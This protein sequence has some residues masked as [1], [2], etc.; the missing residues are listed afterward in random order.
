MDYNS[1]SESQFRSTTIKLLVALEKSVKDSRDFMTAEFRSNQAEIKNQLIEMQS[2]LEV[3][4]IRVNEE[5]LREINDSLRRKNLHIIGVPES[6]E[7]VRG[8]E[9][10]FE[11][12]I[13]ENFP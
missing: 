12:I 2:K 1:M 8:P 9:C 13:A 3:R 6:A 10:I 4:T 5:R 7:R 11:Q